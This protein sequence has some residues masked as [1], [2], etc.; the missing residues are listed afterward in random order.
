MAERPIILFPKPQ[1]ADRDK[2]KMPIPQVNKPSF[3]K[4]YRRL[5]PTFVVLEE[6]FKKKNISL[7]FLLVHLQKKH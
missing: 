2:R 6:A 3:G 1:L 7:E 5:Q 4:Q